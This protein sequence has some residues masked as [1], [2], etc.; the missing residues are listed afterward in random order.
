[1]TNPV[2]FPVKDSYRTIPHALGFPIVVTS[3]TTL[4]VGPGVIRDWNNTQDINLGGFD[5]ATPIITTLNFSINGINGLDTGTIAASTVYTIFV[6]NDIRGIHIPQVLASASRTA[7]VLPFGY[8]DFAIIGY[9]VT[10]SSSHLI[11]LNICG[12]GP[13]RVAYFDTAPV[14]FS[15]S[16]GGAFAAKSL[17]HLAPAIDAMEVGVIFAFSAATAANSVAVRPTGSIATAGVVIGSSDV[18]TVLQTFNEP[19]VTRLSGGYPSFD[20][21]TTSSSDTLSA[22]LYW[23]KYAI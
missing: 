5:T 14:I 12:N 20:V 3:N 11:I 21:A 10:D 13:E 8:N 15:G 7:P 4:T 18:V 9:A 16:A 17:Q 22:S 19:V 6:I 1:M 2:M 23:F